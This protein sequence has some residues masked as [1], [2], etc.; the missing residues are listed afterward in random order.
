MLPKPDN[1]LL[2]GAV[3]VCLALHLLFLMPVAN[4]ALALAKDGMEHFRLDG[5]FRTTSA[6]TQNYGNRIL[7][8]KD[9][10]S[11]LQS[12]LRICAKGYPLPKVG[13]EAHLVTAFTYA[14][15]SLFSAGGSGLDTA[16]T[17]TAYR[18][19]DMSWDFINNKKNR[20]GHAWFDRLNVRLTLPDAD[21]C[22][23]RQAI[24][25]GKTY[26]WSPLDLYLPFD[27]MQFDQDYKAGVDAFR[28]DIPLGLFSGI[29]LVYVP[30]RELDMN[31]NYSKDRFLD[32]SWFGSSLLLRGFANLFGWDVALQGGKVY[33][34]W[35][36][37]AGMVGDINSYQIRV[38]AARFWAD[39]GGALLSLSRPA[40]LLEDSL[41]AVVGIGRHWPSSLDIQAECLFNGGGESDDI[42]LGL[43]RVWRR[44][45][46]QA[47]R[48]LAGIM[49]SYEFTPLIL[50]QA[51]M[52]YS[53][54]DGSMQLQP[55]LTWSTS[56]NS[57][58]L[59]GATINKGGRPEFTPTGGI[60]FESEFGTYPNSFFAQFKVYF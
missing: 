27:P 35:H 47:G 46:M 20:A 40:P 6:L 15:G 52:L 53:Q 5:S 42:S 30:G 55:T 24:S 49:V 59:L 10:D 26:F 37:G 34:G 16:G 44:A 41:A 13:Y 58:L 17:D 19:V 38:E 25:F 50:G 9:T 32:A 3:I 7:F 33:G 36:V 45:V 4:C 12:I 48:I 51:A 18:A 60:L 14:D 8:E 11:Y 21:L 39:S 57:E 1:V 2:K 43:E 23:G 22:I 29:N 54:T 31:D 28:I 56:D